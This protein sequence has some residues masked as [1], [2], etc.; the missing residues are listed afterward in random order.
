MGP[1]RTR[2]W[3]HR[4][5]SSIGDRPRNGHDHGGGNDDEDWDAPNPMDWYDGLYRGSGW[6]QGALD[7]DILETGTYLMES[8]CLWTFNR[9]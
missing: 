9:D 4:P 3:H 7:E 8:G 5:G 1:H 6:D 2:G